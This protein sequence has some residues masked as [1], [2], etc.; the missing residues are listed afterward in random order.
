MAQNISGDSDPVQY[1][2]LIRAAAVCRDLADRGV[3]KKKA[4]AKLRGV[5]DGGELPRKCR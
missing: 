2:K 3:G 4:F 5:L 1:V